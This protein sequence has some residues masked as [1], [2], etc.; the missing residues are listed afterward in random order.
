MTNTKL[1]EVLQSGITEA[2]VEK[3]YNL[4]RKESQLKKICSLE[5]IKYREATKQYYIYINRKQY[6]GRTREDLIDSLYN[7]FLGIQTS[8]MNDLFSD[9]MLYRR[10]ETKTTAKTLKEHISLWNNH[11][12]DTDI[13]T[14]CIKDIKP[15]VLTNYFVQLTK[16]K[17]LTERRCK[18]IKDVI[19]CILKYA[20][21]KEIISSNPA[22]YI[23]TS[24]CTFKQVNTKRQK[25]S[26]IIKSD[27]RAKIIKYLESMNSNSIYDLAIE[28]AFHST[29]RIGEIKAIKWSDIDYENRCVWIDK[30]I[31]ET[32]VM[33][34]D[35]TFNERTHVETDHIK[36][37][38][39]KGMRDVFLSDASIRILEKIKNM[40]ID[41]E[42][43]F[44]FDGKFLS[45]VTFNR[46]LA[47]ICN[48]VGLSAHSSHDIRF[49]GASELY[50]ATKDEKQ[51]QEAL[52]HTTLSMTRHYIEDVIDY[53]ERKCNYIQALG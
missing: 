38:T 5:K 15:A 23:D 25:R 42:Y 45:T 37:N 19:S 50:H 24:N 3:L 12:K 13:A 11:I 26:K 51:V 43:V 22:E 31:I 35:L 44:L 41:N 32:Q 46:H 53:D 4:M 16:S 10:D 47:D 52:G 21:Q 14:M 29:L 49:S 20:I 28:F 48:A 2:E 17:S 33:N 40:H 7:T 9:Y 8:S 1:T 18:D 39:Q 6:T 27:A 30:Q 36:G 34:D